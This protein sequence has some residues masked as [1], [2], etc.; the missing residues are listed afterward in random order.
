[1]MNQYTVYPQAFQQ[2]HGLLQSQQRTIEDLQNQLNRLQSEFKDLQLEPRTV[3]YKFDQLKIERLEGTLNIGLGTGKANGDLQDVS[4]DG[5]VVQ[6]GTDPEADPE[7]LHAIQRDVN[8]YMK[9]G[10]WNALV[11]IENQHE[12]PLDDPY[13]Q[14]I[15]Q[16]IHKQIDPRIRYY[17]KKYCSEGKGSDP[18]TPGAIVK[19]VKNDIYTGMEDFVKKL[20]QGSD[21][22]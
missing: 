5:N 21:S 22:S 16:D 10:A 8:Q 7:M 1:M 13:R 4:V 19:H 14:F 12:H 18:Q 11:Q 2:M 20:K 17:Y 9:D 3:E 15:L 6:P